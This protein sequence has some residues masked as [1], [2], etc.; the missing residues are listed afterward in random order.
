MVSHK[1]ADTPRANPRW[2]YNRCTGAVGIVRVDDKN[3]VGVCVF[4]VEVADMSSL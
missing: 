4:L 3:S 2:R 1:T